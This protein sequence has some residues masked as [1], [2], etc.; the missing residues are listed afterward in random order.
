MAASTIGMAAAIAASLAFSLNDVGIKFMSG[1]YPLHQIVLTRASVGLLF[2]LGFFMRLEGGL[3][4]IRTQR[5]GLH[6]I[7][8]LCVVLANMLFFLGLAAIPLAEASA[9][10]FVSPVIITL[11]SVIFLGEIVGR[12]RWLAVFAGLAGTLIM[13][14]PGL[15]T[16]QY[17]ALYSIGS[18]VCYATLHIFTRKLGATEKAS[19]LAFYIQLMFVFVSAAVGLAIGDGRYSGTG[20]PSLDFLFRA[21]VM[22]T[23]VDWLIMIGIG[24]ASATGGYMISQAYRNCEAAVIAPFEYVSLIMA[25]IWGMTVFDE[26]PDAIAWVGMTLILV[27]GMLVFWRENVARRVVAA[28]RPLPY[29]R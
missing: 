11:F 15:G 20:D 12:L 29:R 7:R 21:W 9:I 14:R 8:G 17:A 26:W 18:A 4:N 16:F 6:I 23:T 5:L 2:T 24:F 25:I 13:L 10:F 27:G 1:D 3:V 28:E 19:T 22:P